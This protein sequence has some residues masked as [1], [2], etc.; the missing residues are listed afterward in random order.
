ME[1]RFEL[2]LHVRKTVHRRNGRGT[3]VIGDF[4]ENFTSGLAFWTPEQ[5]LE[6]WC[7]VLRLM[8]SGAERGCF[9]THMDSDLKGDNGYGMAWEF[10]RLDEVIAFHNRLII[11]EA[12]IEGLASMDP[13]PWMNDYRSVTEDGQRI[14]EWRIPRKNLRVNLKLTQ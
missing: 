5:Y 13:G 10:Y 6:N 8:L 2:R 12:P 11:P 3:I 14:S 4:Q 7:N 9:I 1:N